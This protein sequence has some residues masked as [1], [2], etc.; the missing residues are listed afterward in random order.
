MSATKSAPVAPPLVT[1]DDDPVERAFRN[2]P[3]DERPLSDEEVAALSEAR[4]AGG[5]FVSHAEAMA[6]VRA[7]FNVE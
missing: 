6:A 7:R 5:P 3:V 1:E 4:E 2:A